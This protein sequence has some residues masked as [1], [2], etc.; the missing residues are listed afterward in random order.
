M[1][2]FCFT[3]AKFSILNLTLV[4]ESM[5]VVVKSMVCL[6]AFVNGVGLIVIFLTRRCFDD[7]SPSN[8]GIG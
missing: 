5:I 6:K 7:E 8:L 3:E 2:C 4:A 1:F